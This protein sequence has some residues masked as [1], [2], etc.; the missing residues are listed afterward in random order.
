MLIARK[1]KSAVSL[2]RRQGMPGVEEVARLRA[3]ALYRSHRPIP[4]D[5]VRRARILSVM[6]NRWSGFSPVAA[7]LDPED[8]VRDSILIPY[9]R[10]RFAEAVAAV[11]GADCEA[12]L[13]PLEIVVLAD[14]LIGLWEYRRI[15][16]SLRAWTAA[17]EATP[18]ARRIAQ[19]GRRTSTATEKTWPPWSSAAKSTTPWAVWMRREPRSRLP[20]TAT[21]AIAMH[22]SSTASTFSRPASF[23]KACRTGPRQTRLRVSTLCVVTVRPGPVSPWAPA[24]S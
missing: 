14:C 16:A 10:H 1:L 4:V 9:L 21:E 17:V 20:C 22:A 8:K 13:L 6:L 24:I 19:V 12:S 5:G 11:D 2:Y 15:D 3:A 18:Y 23:S 7:S